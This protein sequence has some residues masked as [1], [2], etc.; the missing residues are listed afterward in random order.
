MAFSLLIIDIELVDTV[1]S[2]ARVVNDTW[3]PYTVPPGYVA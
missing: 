2:A 3:L 1:G